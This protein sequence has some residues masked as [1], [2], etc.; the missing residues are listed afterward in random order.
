MKVLITGHMGYIGAKLYSRCILEGYDVKGID[1]KHGKDILNILDDKEYLDFK[2]EII[3]HMAA[4][5]S[6]QYSVENPSHTLQNN[7]LGTSRIL[8]YAKKNNCKKVIFSSSSAIYGNNNFPVSPYG[9]HKLQ[10]EMECRLYSELYNLDTVCLRYFNVY[11]RDQKPSGA[12]PTVI[13]A[14]MDKIRNK[15]EC[16]IYGDGTH[17]RD[18]IHVDDIVDCNLFLGLYDKKLNGSCFDVG[19]GKNYSVNHIKNYILSKYDVKFKNLDARKSDS[20]STIADTKQLNEI[21]WYAK[22]NFDYGLQQCFSEENIKC[23]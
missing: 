2:P 5:P 6:V 15:K 3:F 12:Y 13:S 10:S 4:L 22:V 20:L 16:I 23:V 17:L 19:T 14:W 18:Y 9:L 8:E 7:T 1:L 21:G 11:S